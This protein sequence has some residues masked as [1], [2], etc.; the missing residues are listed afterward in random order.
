RKD[1][2]VT[3]AFGVQDMVVGW[4]RIVRSD[5]P[6]HRLVVVNATAYTAVDAAETDEET[7]FAVNA[8]GPALLATACAKV[9]ARLIHVSTDYVFPGDAD[10]PYEVDDQTGPKSVYGRTK[11]AGEEAVREILPDA[12]C[13][14]RTAWVYGASGQNFVK[15]M[16]RL[17]K[18]RDTVSVVDDQR[19]SPTW[20]RDLANGLLALAGSDV[21]AGVLH[22]TNRGETT[23]YGFT[24]AIFEE[25]GADPERVRPTTT[26]AFPRPAP[27]PAYSVLS[28]RSWDEAGLPP[29]PDWRSALAAA[30][31]TAGDAFRG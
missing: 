7:A 4:S 5:N 28:P 12:A 20:S 19:G 31:R 16:V 25:L 29:L 9:G 21:R 14:V 23:W 24:K 13:V 15:T 11:L 2:D 3:D 6:D 26:D 18:E 1:L 10:R 22:A 30:F 8:A 17:E 27:R